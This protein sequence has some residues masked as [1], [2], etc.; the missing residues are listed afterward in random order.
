MLE[1]DVD[2][3]LLDSSSLALPLA[4]FLAERLAEVLSRLAV[5][6]SGED[7]SDGVEDDFRLLFTIISL[8]LAL[9]LSTQY[10]SNKI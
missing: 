6:L 1:R 4:E 7:V 9:I 10:N 3:I 5:H 8:E 2:G